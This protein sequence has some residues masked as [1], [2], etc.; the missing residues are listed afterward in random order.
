MKALVVDDSNTMR[1]VLRRILSMRGFE[2]AEAKH[3][4]DA[5]DVL[6][7]GEVPDV[8]LVDWNM[9]EMNGLELVTEIRKRPQYEQMRIMMVT[10]E[11]GIKEVQSALNAGAT[12]YLMK[13]FNSMQVEEKLALLGLIA[14]V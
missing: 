13:P 7:K 3:G 1:A 8:A 5:L 10:T 12:D 14:N 11:T 9:P 2:V 4:V 6:T